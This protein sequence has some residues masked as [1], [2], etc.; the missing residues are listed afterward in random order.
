MTCSDAIRNP[1][2]L[3]EANNILPKFTAE[4]SLWRIL[5]IKRN[6]AHGLIDALATDM[7]ITS[8]SNG[9]CSSCTPCNPVTQTQVCQHWN[10]EHTRLHRS[11]A[12]M[13]YWWD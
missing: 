3:K 2:L 6:I 10:Q 12:T 5:S 7:N 13:S 4:M 8:A 11:N 9:F 1:S